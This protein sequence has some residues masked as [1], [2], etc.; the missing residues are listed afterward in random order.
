MTE[1]MNVPEMETKRERM[2]RE[3]RP[4]FVFV[5]IVTLFLRSRLT[6]LFKGNICLGE[7]VGDSE[8]AMC[9]GRLEKSSGS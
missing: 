2:S 8:E 6:E 3:T 7:Q 5:V 4:I 9:K 1:E